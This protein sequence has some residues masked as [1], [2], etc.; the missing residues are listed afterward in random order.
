[1]ARASGRALVA[2][3][4]AIAMTNAVPA[5]APDI[6]SSTAQPVAWAT[7]RSAGVAPEQV[8]ASRPDRRGPA[9]IALA[10]DKE[11]TIDGKH[12]DVARNRVAR[13]RTPGD[14]RR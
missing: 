5:Q 9:P 7:A 10:E 11:R 8:V 2:S 6:A 14:G 12:Y 13:G 3:V 1:M 4:S